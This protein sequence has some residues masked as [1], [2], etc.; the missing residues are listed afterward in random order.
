M[1]DFEAVRRAY[2]SP[3]SD[4]VP[5]VEE[6]IGAYERQRMADAIE[7]NLDPEA[8]AIGEFGSLIGGPGKPTTF[9]QGGRRA[10]DMVRMPPMPL[11]WFDHENAHQRTPCDDP[12]SY[13]DVL[14][15]DHL[16]G[17]HPRPDG[18]TLSRLLCADCLTSKEAVL[19]EDFLARLRM[20]ELAYLL[21]R[22][23]LT[24]YEIARAMLLSGSR[25][26]AKTHWI[27]QFATRPEPSESATRM[28]RPHP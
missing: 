11:P 26:P 14:S 17:L 3:P 10:E 24:I 1:I 16:A 19:V 2:Y 15:A 5:S 28:A 7:R 27:N 12:H 23:G 21:S 4:S 25:T 8:E 22:C 20:I 13:L 9:F 6:R 18:Q